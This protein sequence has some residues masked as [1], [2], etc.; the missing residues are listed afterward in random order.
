MQL[1]PSLIFSALALSALL[2]GCPSSS[3]WDADQ[4]AVHKAMLEWS[5]AVTRQSADD[6]WDR[7]S[8]DAQDLYKRE[9]EGT[10]PAGVRATVSL[11]KAA[12]DPEALTSDNDRARIKALLATLPEDPDSMTPKDYYIW[13]MK[14]EFTAEGA[15]NT[16]R[17]FSRSNIDSITIEGETATVMLKAGDPKRY[18]WVRHD[19]V[20]K[21]DVKPSILRALETA[22]K[23]EK[24]SD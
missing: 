21:F 6:M 23:R 10:N 14:P 16:A 4:E 20:W 15:E 12:L 1:R 3:D 5:S 11:N 22:R 9:L 17:L 7:L 8:P 18:S 2:A 24:Q 19:G 13:R